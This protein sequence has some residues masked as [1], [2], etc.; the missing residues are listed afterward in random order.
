MQ[1]HA[2]HLRVF[3]EIDSPRILHEMHPFMAKAGAG[4]GGGHSDNC[5]ATWGPRGPGPACVLVLCLLM[6]SVKRKVGK[7]DDN[8]LHVLKNGH[9][10]GKWGWVSRRGHR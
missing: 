5:W 6:W 3:R 2:A 8:R 4:G 1:H 10:E 9:G 7:S